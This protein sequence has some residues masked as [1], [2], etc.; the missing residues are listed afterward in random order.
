MPPNAQSIPHHLLPSGIRVVFPM[1]MGFNAQ[2]GWIVDISVNT[3]K[4]FPADNPFSSFLSR[5]LTLDLGSNLGV[6]SWG[7]NIAQEAEAYILSL[8]SFRWRSDLKFSGDFS[9]CDHLISLHTCLE[10]RQYVKLC[11]QCQD[12]GMSGIWS[13]VQIHLG[14]GK[15]SWYPWWND[16]S[17][18]LHWGV[19]IYQTFTFRS[20]VN[21]P[22]FY[23]KNY[24][25][26]KWFQDL[27]LSF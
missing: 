1:A 4:T 22:F 26:S 18:S 5:L 25:R 24:D 23:L 20:F 21:F 13:G 16:N 8:K 17:H 9:A 27:F 15:E 10:Y 11:A 7:C 19:G 6:M 12:S 2:N 14:R 3:F